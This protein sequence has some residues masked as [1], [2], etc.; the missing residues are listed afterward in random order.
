M[1]LA[2]AY[3]TLSQ[4]LLTYRHPYYQ[5]TAPPARG[6]ATPQLAS[7]AYFGLITLGPLTCR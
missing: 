7:G 2:L 1:M 3:P 6:P 5:A 4:R